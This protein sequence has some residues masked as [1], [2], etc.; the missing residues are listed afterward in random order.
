MP[1]AEQPAV[2]E[3]E[4]TD[5]TQSVRQALDTIGAPVALADL[6]KVLV[7]PNLVVAKPPPI[8]TPVECVRAVVEYV[9]SHSAASIVIAEGCGAAEYDTEKVFADLGYVEL[10]RQ[11]GLK[12]INLNTAAT[13]TLRNSACEIFPEFHIP[14]IAMDHYIISVPVLKA[15]SFSA[16]TGSMKNMMGFAPPRHYQQGGH[17]KKSA[18]H[19]HMHQAILDLNSYRRADLSVM[20]A[21]VGLCDYH[22]GGRQCSPPVG[23]ILASFDP[24]LLDRRAAELLGMHWSQIPHLAEK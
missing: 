12:L 16:I 22:L 6:K 23:K 4:F 2:A 10:A 3:V 14:A 1:P 7:K 24:K 9:R 5:F 21:T 20:D 11:V 13:V 15:H 19:A 8:T 17:W 18:F